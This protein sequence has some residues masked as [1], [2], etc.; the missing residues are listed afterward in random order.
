ML[1]HAGETWQSDAWLVTKSIVAKDGTQSVQLKN[2][3]TERFI[4]TNATKSGS[5]AYP[6]YMGTTAGNVT[7]TFDPA[8]GDYTLAL[9]ARNFFPVAATSGTLPGIISSGSTI[10]DSRNAI[11]PQG[12]AWNVEQVYTVAYVCK[13]TEGNIIG[14]YV[15]SAPAGKTYTCAAPEIKNHS[16]KTYELTGTAAAPEFE[17]LAENKTVNVTYQRSAYSIS[18][19]SRD[20]YGAIIDESETSCPVGESFSIAYPELPYYT[21][22]SS[23]YTGEETIVPTEDMT[24]NAVYTTNAVNGVK[25]LGKEVTAVEAGK[26]YVIYD[27]CTSE[28]ARKGYR[29]A[30]AK[31]GA[32]VK[33]NN[34]ED[35][36]PYYTWTLEASGTKFK[37]LNNGAGKYVPS[38]KNST[39]A[40]LSDTGDNFAFTR[41]AD[42]TWKI[43]G[44]NNVCWDGL[45]AGALVGWNDP[46][47]PYR[48]YE[49]YA[50]PYFSVTVNAVDE[51]TSAALATTAEWVKAGEAY[52]LVAPTIEGYYLKSTEGDEGLTA[53]ADNTVVTLTYAS[54]NTGIEKVE[55]GNANAPATIY[56]LS[57][58]RLGGISRSGIYI[59]N[60]RKVLVK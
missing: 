25:R 4:S 39:A 57:G 6:V 24:I 12:A 11:R 38:L 1:R 43:K 59:V 28:A 53:V 31:T 14:T 55:S 23:D 56:D 42:G 29:M 13:D 40:F 2:A 60:G 30:N 58:R 19:V 45:A 44:S 37:V 51:K 46:G 7:L 10:D 48:I 9:T 49:Y 3:A 17:N 32:V 52:T 50:Q 21:Y 54:N 22:E 47:H 16:V 15:Q 20:Q 41:N 33:D 35:T 26:T 18:L 36:T 5:V 8:N 34:I 27:D